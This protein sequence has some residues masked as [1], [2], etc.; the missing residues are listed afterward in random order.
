MVHFGGK[1]CCSSPVLYCMG[2]LGAAK[3][4]RELHYT[5]NSMHGKYRYHIIQ[6]SI[7]PKFAPMQPTVIVYSIHVREYIIVPLK[8][9]TTDI[10]H[11]C[12]KDILEGLDSRNHYTIKNSLGA[13][14]PAG[15][16]ALRDI[17]IRKGDRIL[18]NFKE[19][20]RHQRGSYVSWPVP[21]RETCQV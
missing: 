3:P 6:R 12:L 9:G 16:C 17:Y 15:C 2:Q 7:P 18:R 21:F 11:S 10:A 19:T 20:R 5:C 4:Y 14:F 8:D 13:R 1:G